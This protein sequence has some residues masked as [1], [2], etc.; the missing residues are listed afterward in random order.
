MDG[1][2]QQQFPRVP[3]QIGHLDDCL[4]QDQRRYAIRRTVSF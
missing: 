1:L 4:T 3:L 2:R